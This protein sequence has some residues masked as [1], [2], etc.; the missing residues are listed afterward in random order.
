MRPSPRELVADDAERQ[1]LT[2]PPT[3]W[4]TR[5]AI[6]TPIDVVNAASREPAPNATSAEQHAFLADDVTDAAQNRGRHRRG[7]QIG[8]HH[9]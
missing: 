7:Q 2:P 4:M 9:Q 1:G 8:R 6:M 3:P 5:A